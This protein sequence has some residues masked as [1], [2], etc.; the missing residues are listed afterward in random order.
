MVGGL[1]DS[2]REVGKCSFL[3]NFLKDGDL[4]KLF[5]SSKIYTKLF[6]PNFAF[7]ARKP[8]CVVSLCI[9]ITP[10]ED[11]SDTDQGINVT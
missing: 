11:P 4:L 6:V 10:C 5:Q 1:D 8:V 3:T 7:F 2:V 9:I